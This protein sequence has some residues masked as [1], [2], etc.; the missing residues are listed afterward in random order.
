V[1]CVFVVQ[2]SDPEDA[3]RDIANTSWGLTSSEG[4]GTR[5]RGVV[6]E[7]LKS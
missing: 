1:W 5:G 6:M 3:E 7:A 2:A 4:I